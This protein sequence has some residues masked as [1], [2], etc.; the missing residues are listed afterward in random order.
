MSI[1][2]SEKHGVNPSIINCFWCGEAMGI[3]LRGKMKGDVA[4]PRECFGGYDPCDECQKKWDQG[5]I[6]V[7]VTT[8]P[9]GGPNQPPLQEGAYPTGSF[10]VITKEYAERLGIMTKNAL[11]TPEDA[12]KLGL[13]IKEK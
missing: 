13:F 6:I 4:A 2:L 7:E 11:I 8:E 12:E 10:A 9:N 5:V 3:A 1:R